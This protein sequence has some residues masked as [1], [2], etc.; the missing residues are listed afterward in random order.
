MKGNEEKALSFQK[1]GFF[2]PS[3]AWQ[4][5]GGKNQSDGAAG[6]GL[7]SLGESSP[8]WPVERSALPGHTAVLDLLFL[9]LFGNISSSYSPFGTAFICLSPYRDITPGKRHLANISAIPC[10]YVCT[11]VFK[12]FLFL[13]GRIFFF[14]VTQTAIFLKMYHDFSLLV[15]QKGSLQYC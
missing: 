9:L 8:W 10:T 3:P 6:L 14:V 15:S 7:D 11:R 13:V 5:G 2:L 4:A 1:R 12:I